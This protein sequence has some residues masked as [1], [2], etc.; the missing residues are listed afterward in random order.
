MTVLVSDQDTVA[1]EK[2]RGGTVSLP[3][4]GNLTDIRKAKMDNFPHPERRPP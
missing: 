2:G 1:P 3:A 4:G